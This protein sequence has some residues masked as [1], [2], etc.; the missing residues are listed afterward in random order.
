[1][2]RGPV[3]RLRSL[4]PAVATAAAPRRSADLASV[5]ELRLAF[6][7]DAGKPRVDPAALTHLRGLRRRRPVGARTPVA[8]A[9]RARR[10]GLRG[11]VLDGRHRTSARAGSPDC[12]TTRASVTSGTRGRSPDV[13]SRRMTR[14][15]ASSSR[16]RRCGTSSSSFPARLAGGISRAP[17]TAWGRPVIHEKKTLRRAVLEAAKAGSP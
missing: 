17:M 10:R 16:A 12:S 9:P 7:H 14:R 13:G 6:E 8:G 2:A 4:R 11:V 3:S 5:D 15:S 1:M